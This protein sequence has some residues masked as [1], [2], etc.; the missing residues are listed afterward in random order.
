[1][2]LELRAFFSGDGQKMGTESA[3]D[4]QPSF[5]CAVLLAV[6]V[7]C[8]HQ[9]MVRDFE[10][11]AW[12]GVR[13]R[14]V[15]SGQQALDVKA[16]PGDGAMEGDWE[17]PAAEPFFGRGDEQL[18][19]SASPRVPAAHSALATGLATFVL[20]IVSTLLGRALDSF[21]PK[22]WVDVVASL[23]LSALVGAARYFLFLAADVD[24]QV[25]DERGQD[26]PLLTLRS[27]VFDFYD[28]YGAVSL[29]TVAGI[30]VA[31]W[32]PEVQALPADSAAW[33]VCLTFLILRLGAEAVTYLASCLCNEA[34]DGCAPEATDPLWGRFYLCSLFGSAVLQFCVFAKSRR[35]RDGNATHLSSQQTFRDHVTAAQWLLT[36]LCVEFVAG[37]AVAVFT[38]WEADSAATVMLV[39]LSSCGA[40][41]AL[42]VGAAWRFS[43]GDARGSRQRSFA[44]RVG[45]RA[46]TAWPYDEHVLC[47]A[48]IH[49]LAR[50]GLCLQQGATHA[51]LTAMAVLSVQRAVGPARCGGWELRRT[52]A[53]CL[54][55]VLATVPLC[56]YA[57]R[58]PS[59]ARCSICRWCKAP[60]FE[61]RGF[62][63][64]FVR[65]SWSWAGW[66]S[67]MCANAPSAVLVNNWSLVSFACCG[68]CG[69]QREVYV[70]EADYWEFISRLRVL[71][72]L[73][74]TVVLLLTTVVSDLAIGKDIGG[75]C[76]HAAGVHWLVVLVAVLVVRV[77]AMAALCRRSSSPSCPCVRQLGTGIKDI[78]AAGVD[79]GATR[80]LSSAFAS[81]HIP[82]QAAHAG[83]Q[84][85]QHVDGGG[86]DDEAE[87]E[88]EAQLEQLQ[89]EDGDGDDDEA[90][91][92]AGAQ[93]EQL[94][95]EDGD[96]DDGE[97]DVEA[98]AQLEAQLALEQHEANSP[99]T[100]RA[101]SYFLSGGGWNM[102]L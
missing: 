91:V 46:R 49:P 55:T 25:L 21:G 92:E 28:A 19:P 90:E 29:L 10:P 38:A 30:V 85:E 86:N 68:C 22:A 99:P 33:S 32:G 62:A 61:R 56:L 13:L 31:L 4:S 15:G 50:F 89:H 48:D 14:R 78:D 47:T 76:A 97:A 54:Y 35:T 24:D 60:E 100:P 36:R 83:A 43:V 51:I 9:R 5:P 18:A 93:L 77:V 2:L 95:H 7:T 70:S 53:A 69:T 23:V 16:G 52:V 27:V 82:M 44:E 34:T 87:V 71:S 8:P 1:M 84:P 39:A 57:L 40:V 66:R 58:C 41:L 75:E 98:G 81:F 11:V 12:P 102:A 65:K 26:T 74:L 72:M 79:G 20:A 67:G 94:Q 80:K 59:T 45:P 17:E 96:G 3:G 6:L 63:H 101:E 64:V 88:A 37:T 42:L 73:P